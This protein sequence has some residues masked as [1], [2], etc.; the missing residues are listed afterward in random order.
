MYGRSW[1]KCRGHNIHLYMCF[2]DYSKAFDC[3]SHG[4]LWN[5]M[6]TMVFPEH[7]ISLICMLY[8]NQESAV[9]TGA[10]ITEWFKVGRGV[11]QGCI[12]SPSLYNLYA[13]DIMRTALEEKVWGVKVGGVRRSNLRYADYT[14]LLSSSKEELL[15]MI[16][17]VKEASQPRGLLLNV[18]KTQIMVIDN[19]RLDHTDFMI[20]GE[21]ISEVEE[22]VYLGSKITKA[23]NCRTE[24]RRRLAMARTATLNMTSIWKSRGVSTKL[25]TRLLRATTFAIASYGCE[26]CAMTKADQGKVDAFEMWAYRRVLRVSWTAMKTNKWVLDKIGNSLVLRS[27]MMER[28]L[29]FSP[30]F[31]L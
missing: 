15:R 23:C 19:N 20:D 14:T 13:E 9:R 11:R 22:F 17:A 12:L 16:S 30:I 8:G 1:E 24:V 6:R 28:K 3:V 2:I 31:V 27:Q 21:R 25:K 4:Q 29:K 10:G 7:L 18:K 26:S 5:I